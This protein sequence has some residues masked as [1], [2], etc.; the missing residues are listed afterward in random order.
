MIFIT[1]FELLR[2]IDAEVVRLQKNAGRKLS[3]YARG[4]ITENEVRKA[5]APAVPVSTSPHPRLAGISNRLDLLVLRAGADLHYCEYD[6]SDVVVPIEVKKRGI[7]GPGQVP[8]LRH[9]FDTIQQVYPAVRPVYLTIR[10]RANYRYR[11]TAENLGH[12]IFTLFWEERGVLK[13][14]GDWAKFCEFVTAAMPDASGAAS[15]SS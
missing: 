10:E 14:S 2:R 9:C 5:I 13:A 1:E 3:T 12:T 15:T 4:A 11:A 6:G 8:K 7:C